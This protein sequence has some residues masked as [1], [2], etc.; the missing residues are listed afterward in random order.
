[1]RAKP[2]GLLIFDCRP[3]QA[4]RLNVPVPKRTCADSQTRNDFRLD[5]SPIPQ[6][7][8]VGG[9]LVGR[10][11]TVDG[12]IVREGARGFRRRGDMQLRFPGERPFASG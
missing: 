1:M 4:Y 8:L 2:A 5:R 12:R 7:V 10:F 9:H 6:Q 3:A 11:C